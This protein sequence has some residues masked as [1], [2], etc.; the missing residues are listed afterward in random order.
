MARVPGFSF[1]MVPICSVTKTALI[2][3]MI[4]PIQ[5]IDDSGRRYYLCKCHMRPIAYRAGEAARG[6]DDGDDDK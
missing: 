6:G 1:R 2:R 3:E 4:T 5:E